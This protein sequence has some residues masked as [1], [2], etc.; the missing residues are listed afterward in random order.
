MARILVVDDAAFMRVRA[1]KVLQDH[2]H[3]VEMAENGLE[4]ITKYAE[5]RPDAV[6]MDITMPEMDGLAA[7]KEIRKSDPLAR[8]AMVTAMGQQAI[9]MEAL[10]AGAKDFVLKPVQP[11]PVPRAL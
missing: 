5:W 9:V 1:A 7:L 6:L 3:E 4:A 10:K 2:G 8:V 11:H